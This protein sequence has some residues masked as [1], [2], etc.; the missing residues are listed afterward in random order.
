MQ[1]FM[2]LMPLALIFGVNIWLFRENRKKSPAER[3]KDDEI[4]AKMQMW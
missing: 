1:L 3:K 4:K 2:D